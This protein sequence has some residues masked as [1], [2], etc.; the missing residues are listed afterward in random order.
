MLKFNQ[1][2]RIL[3]GVVAYLIAYDFLFGPFFGSKKTLFYSLN[4]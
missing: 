4:D 3:C 1:S 2:Q